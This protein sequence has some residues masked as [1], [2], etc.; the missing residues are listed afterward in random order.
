MNM[1]DSE[2]NFDSSNLPVNKKLKA[3]KKKRAAENSYE[4]I[5]RKKSAAIYLR[6]SSEMQVDGF[7]IEAQKIAC[8]KYAQEQGYEVTDDHIYIDEAFS[9]K[10]E[11]RPEFKRLMVAAHSSEFSMI[12]I[13][14]MDRFERNFRAMT[15]TL[16]DLANIGVRVYSIYENLELANTLTVNLFGI[17]HI[18]SAMDRIC[19]FGKC[20][21]H[22]SVF[23]PSF[24]DKE[25]GHSAYRIS[26]SR[27]RKHDHPS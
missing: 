23:Y 8:L 6:V 24:R 17:R 12:I 14:K 13:H 22:N 11:D 21:V 19:S 9:A 10:N 1:N 5:Q 4:A 27:S 15:N 2:N 7:S 18:E 3:I 16:E 25:Q 26:R 20:P